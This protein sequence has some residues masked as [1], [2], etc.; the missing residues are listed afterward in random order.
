MCSERSN[1]VDKSFFKSS[2]RIL[3]AI[4]P[5]EN[6]TLG[7]GPSLSTCNLPLAQ[8][9]LESIKDPFNNQLADDAMAM[10]ITEN[11]H[12]H[13]FY[14]IFNH[15]MTALYRCLPAEM[16]EQSNIVYVPIP[17]CSGTTILPPALHE[18]S[19]SVI[20]QMQTQANYYLQIVPKETTILF[21][22][23]LLEEGANASNIPETFLGENSANYSLIYS[24]AKM[25]D[26]FVCVL[27]ARDEYRREWESKNENRLFINPTVDPVLI[28]DPPESL[29]SSADLAPFIKVLP[30][31]LAQ[32]MA[33]VDE[34]KINNPYEAEVRQIL[35]NLR[36]ITA[37][38]VGLLWAGI[39]RNFPHPSASE[40]W[41]NLCRH[42]NL[43]IVGF[44][45]SISD[46]L[47]FWH[48]VDLN[49]PDQLDEVHFENAEAV[50]AAIGEQ[51]R[52][53]YFFIAL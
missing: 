22:M 18:Q 37:N 3:H 41:S 11:G 32:L 52:M 27:Y 45:P 40:I 21:F 9:L 17:F 47:P 44:L 46:L 50:Y 19:K 35:L 15:I 6:L 28:P 26:E 1:V 16:R 23:V 36:E 5:L 10:L 42:L 14:G 7:E 34:S 30:D 38:D 48:V 2:T 43:V 39:L 13:N 20:E 49:N 51:I 29:I 25:V 53:T 8:A 12:M 4:G 31:E 24:D 33:G